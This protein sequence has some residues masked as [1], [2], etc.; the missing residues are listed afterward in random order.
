MCM[1]L[2]LA[3]IRPRSMLAVCMSGSARTRVHDLHH[4]VDSVRLRQRLF[5][6]GST[7]PSELSSEPFELSSRPS[8]LSRK[9]S[10]LPCKPSKL[11]SKP[12][13]EPPS[14][15]ANGLHGHGDTPTLRSIVDQAKSRFNIFLNIIQASYISIK[16]LHA[17]FSIMVLRLIF[18][19]HVY[20]LKDDVQFC[21]ATRRSVTFSSM[22]PRKGLVLDFAPTR[23]RATRSALWTVSTV[24]VL[25]LVLII[26]DNA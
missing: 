6:Y 10:E 12:S 22:L 18:F 3:G 7:H 17:V 16:F 24:K 19:V 13:S 4:H 26:S 9:P 20:H 15:P 1:H 2:L 25:C 23:A 8:E 21:H 11:L 5:D 14:C